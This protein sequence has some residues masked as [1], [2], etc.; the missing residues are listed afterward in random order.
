MDEQHNCVLQLLRKVTGKEEEDG[1]K[2]R[3]S[4]I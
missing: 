3:F 4:I 1:T 2:Q